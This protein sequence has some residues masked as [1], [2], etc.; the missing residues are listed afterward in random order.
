MREKPGVIAAVKASGRHSPLMLLAIFL[1]SSPI[2][3]LLMMVQTTPQGWLT[4]LV[5]ACFAGAIS[6][7]WAYAFMSGR[8]WVIIPAVAVSVAVPKL[9]ALLDSVTGMLQVGTGLSPSARLVIL[10][11]M[12]IALT[13]SG[14]IV[15]DT[16]MRRTERKTARALAELELASEVH[17]SLVPAI[18]L[19]TPRAQV[20]GRSIASS[21]MGGDL[22]DVVENDGGLVV[23][24]GDV[25]GHGVGAGIVM[26]MLKASMRT[27]MLHT[28]DTTRVLDE[29]NKVL[30]QLTEPHMFATF[31]AL[32][33]SAGGE[34]EYAMAGHLPIFHRG[35]A[36]GE[37]V[38]YH[39]QNLPLGIDD[40]ETFTRG[41][42]QLMPGDLLGVFTDGLTEVQDA[43][44]RELGLEGVAALLASAKGAAL[45]EIDQAVMN[46]VRAHGPQ[47]DDQ[48]LVLVRVK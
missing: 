3:V 22:I 28:G 24:L 30:E 25:S 36:T 2:G 27:A 41:T 17:R 40:G 16:Q 47:L 31:A 42:A 46:G 39:N 1:V 45:A 23:L 7:G 43:A 19:D 11:V 44:G 14:F 15:F 8:M 6:V 12:C 13:A 9:F 5:A 20:R 21:A 18:D 29:V 4:G 26:A 33:I 10:A 35:A 32:R 34:L 37:W 48:S 38:Q